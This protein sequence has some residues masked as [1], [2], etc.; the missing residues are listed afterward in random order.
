MKICLFDRKEYK[1]IAQSK[2]GCCKT[3]SCPCSYYY[4]NE[5]HGQRYICSSPL[6]CTIYAS[7]G[8]TRNFL[9]ANRTAQSRISEMNRMIH[10]FWMKPAMQYPTKETAATRSA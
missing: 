9:M 6:F 4:T 3:G 2:R 5:E 7:S 1:Q 10:A 8:I